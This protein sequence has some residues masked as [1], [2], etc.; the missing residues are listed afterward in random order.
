MCNNK[1]NMSHQT[2]SILGTTHN[3]EVLNPP[4]PRCH[5]RK[6]SLVLASLLWGFYDTK[7][8]TLSRLTLIAVAVPW[9]QEVRPR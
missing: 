7:S 4:G 1:H 9:S 2:S 5:N 3:L 6:R 8:S